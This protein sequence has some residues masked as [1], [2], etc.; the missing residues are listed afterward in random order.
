MGRGSCAIIWSRLGLAKYMIVCVALSALGSTLASMVSRDASDVLDE[1]GR[2]VAASVLEDASRVQDSVP[3][4]IV[5]AV[6]AALGVR[7][8]IF[9]SS[10][11]QD[12]FDTIVSVD[13]II[14]RSVEGLGDWTGR[15]H[16]SLHVMLGEHGRAAAVL[17]D[18]A[19]SLLRRLTRP[20][21]PG[22]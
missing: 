9:G 14:V 21:Q 3:A 5:I 11:V 13:Y 18:D 12:P 20:G 16:V 19:I 7:L 1:L 6:I 8:Y 22:R 2:R 10:S 4:T 15:D 17:R